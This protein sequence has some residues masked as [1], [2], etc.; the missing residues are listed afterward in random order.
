MHLRLLALQLCTQKLTLKYFF[1]CSLHKISGSPSS[2]LMEPAASSPGLCSSSPPQRTH[3]IQMKPRK[4]KQQK[5]ALW[6]GGGLFG[7]GS[8]FHEIGT[9]K[10]SRGT[11][12]PVTF[13]DDLLPRV[14]GRSLRWISYTGTDSA[15]CN[16]SSSPLTRRQ[17]SL[18]LPVHVRR[19]GPA[20]GTSAIGLKWVPQKTD[21]DENI[22]YNMAINT[23]ICLKLN[24][25]TFNH[26][27]T[28]FAWNSWLH[29]NTRSSCL[30]SKSLKHTT[31]LQGWERQW[32]QHHR[33]TFTC[34]LGWWEKLTAFVQTGDSLCWTC[35]MEVA[36]CLL[37]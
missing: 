12:A 4:R 37:L 14:E 15:V 28:H 26:L 25:R 20:D 31:H 9:T 6:W 10:H 24:P 13:L 23:T 11:R 33:V 1:F 22:N 34:W 7:I 32:D 29:G 35:R 8:G 3:E 27:S 5:N 18:H 19:V 30:H 2:R 17:F 16:F 21:Y 36:L